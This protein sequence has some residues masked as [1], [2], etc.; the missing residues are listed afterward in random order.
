MTRLLL[1]LL[2]SLLCFSADAA[3]L[4][5]NGSAIGYPAGLDWGSTATSGP[6]TQAPSV[7]TYEVD[8]PDGTTPSFSDLSS[9]RYHHHT[10]VA[11]DSGGRVWVA[12]SGNLTVESQGGIATLINSSANNWST[13]TGPI[14]VIAPPDANSTT[15]NTAYNSSYPRA[16]VTYQGQLYIVAAIDNYANVCGSSNET[17]LALV[18]AA[19]NSNGTIGTPFLISTATYTP[20]SGYPSYTYNSTLGPSLFALANTFGTWGGSAPGYTASAWTGYVSN[21]SCIFTEPSAATQ[22]IGTNPNVLFR[23]W[24]YISGGSCNSSVVYYS[25]S[26]NSG[27]TWSNPVPSNIPNE[28]SETTVIKLANGHIA[29]V[30]NALDISSYTDA[31]DPLYL[32]IFDGT[33]GVLRNIYYVVQGLSGPTYNE[34]VT[35]GVNSKPCGAGYPGVWESNGTLWISFSENKQTI[36]VA[37]VPSTSL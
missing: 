11:V 6:Y 24:R 33:T 30:G 21:A 28:P 15:C 27:S 17:G 18:A 20:T 32:A 22:A 19:C 5:G 1:W 12:Y 14:E 35:C 25:V 13:S 9:L 23:L 31:R 29:V 2:M 37:S 4:H 10:R 3:L 16:F 34:G 7:T 36:W 8:Q 26:A